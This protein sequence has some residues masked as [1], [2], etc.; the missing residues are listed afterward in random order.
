MKT[1]DEMQNTFAHL[2]S[3]SERMTEGDSQFVMSLEWQFQN[4]GQLSNAQKYHLDR[5]ATKYS[6]EEISKQENFE[7]A[8]DDEF[9]LTALRCAQY[10][11]VQHPRYY[12]VIVDKVLSDPSS[13]TLN[14]N[15]FNKMCNNKY[16]K[17]I[18][19]AYDTPHKFS[20]G[21]MV[22][23]RANNR[24]DIANTNTKDGHHPNRASTYRVKDK[25][26]MIIEADAKPI[27]RAAKGARI[28]KI[29]V[30]DETSPIFAHESDLKRVRR[31]KK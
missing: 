19:A 30:I 4:K 31:P 29:L 20:S 3:V 17:K 27:T 2:N 13:H 26:C 22:Q 11:D 12:G 15:E 7:Q 23:I 24:V 1:N 6:M 8:Y 28:Y 21:D 18:L 10:Y 9:R 14:Y 25:T 5:L 16:A